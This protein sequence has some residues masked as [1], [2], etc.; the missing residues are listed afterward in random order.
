[1]QFLV[2]DGSD[3]NDVAENDGVSRDVWQIG[4]V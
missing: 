4:R 1:M 3:D 2:V